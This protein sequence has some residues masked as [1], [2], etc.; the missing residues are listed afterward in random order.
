MPVEKSPETLEDAAWH[1][2]QQASQA[3]LGDA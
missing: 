3:G 1:R 2:A